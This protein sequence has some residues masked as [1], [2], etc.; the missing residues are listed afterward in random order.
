ML[1]RSIFPDAIL[2]IFLTAS[3]QSRAQR[4]YKQLINKGFTANLENLTSDLELRDSRDSSRE[5]AP[6]K[7]A[8]DAILID[9]TSL[10]VDETVGAVMFHYKRLGN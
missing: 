6:L 10:D 8:P 9:S 5:N 2:K 3:A 7:P 4:R 1:F